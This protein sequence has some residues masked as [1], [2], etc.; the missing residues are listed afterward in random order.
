MLQGNPVPALT[1]AAGRPA[2]ALGV[3]AR[4][5]L[6]TLAAVL[7]VLAFAG[8][9]LWRFAE[10]Q[11]GIV[12]RSLVARA[13]GLAR[14]VDSEFE[15]LSSTL[16]AIAGTTAFQAGNLDAVREHML[17]VGRDIGSQVTLRDAGGNLLLHTAIPRGHE[18]G[19]SPPRPGWL[20]L[21]AAGGSGLVVTDLFTGFSNGAQIY[22]VLLPVTDGA[23]RRLLIGATFRADLLMERLRL[24]LPDPGWR[25]LVVDRSHRI[26]AGTTVSEAAL[27]TDAGP[28]FREGASTVWRGQR[29]D[30]V[31]I[32]F[33]HARTAVGWDVGASLAA[34]QV[35]APVRRAVW[36]LVAVGALLLACAVLLALIAARRIARAMGELAE[37]ATVL[38]QGRPVPP[39][40]TSLREA[41]M[42]GAAL[43]RAANTIAARDGALREREAQLARTQRLARVGGFE[44]AVEHRPDGGVRFTNFRSPEYLAV[45]GLP[46]EAA[47]E[48]HE[49]WV[50]RIHPEDRARVTEDFMAAVW[51]GGPDYLSEYR[52]ATPEGETRWISALA[53]VQRDALGR[54]LRFRGVHVDL[55]ALRRAEARLAENRAALAAAEERL[56]LAVEAGG[57]V[58]FDVEVAS[59]RGVFSPGHFALLGQ[60][61]PADGCGDLAS[62][63]AAIHP[64]DRA[65]ARAAWKRML[66]GGGAVTVEHRVLVPAGERW[67]SAT[68]RLL[69]GN[70]LGASPGTSPN[71]QLPGGVRC[72]GVYAD[73]TGRRTAQAVLEERV[74]EAVAAAEAAQA[75]LAHAHKMEA[76]GQL[77]GGVAHDFNNLL[78]VVASGAALLG[79]REAVR[80]DPGARRLLEGMAGAAERGAALT[81]RML[82][83]ARRQELRMGAV[84]TAAL[85]LALRDIL[86]RSIGPAT[87]LEIELPDD[88]WWVLADPNQLELAILN[89]CVN[90]RDAMAPERCPG[91][92]VRVTARNAPAGPRGGL[93]GAGDTPPGGDCLVILV[94][95]DGAGMDAET[96]ARATEPF[97]TTKGVG[98]GTGL[99]L[100]MVHGLCA[101]SG[102]AL[103]LV[104]A[105]GQGTTAEIWLPRAEP[106]SEA[107]PAPVALLPALPAARRLSVLLVDDDPL[108]LA[109]NAAL[110]ADLG[111][112]ARE[113][114]SAAAA[115]EALAAGPLP[116]LVITDHAMPGMTGAELAARLA[117]LHPGLPVILATGYADL[118]AGEA[119]E[120]PR[121][122][123]PFGR[124]ALAAALAAA[125]DEAKAAA[126]AGRRTG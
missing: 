77:T 85:I 57:L 119:P 33:T 106:G 39:I 72:V 4:L 64:E 125:T 122:D 44:V 60:P 19:Q 52:V 26:V 30:G 99:G 15:S 84:D 109:S 93:A 16:R 81:R 34:E 88:L 123:K 9:V 63:E 41:N 7:P 56:R 110:L 20:E 37:A 45:H 21:V 70:S 96:L 112:T 89:L 1:K 105:P 51:G 13:E 55:S 80:A 100:S 32:V 107:A 46:P 111:H 104:S 78:Q 42:V 40:Q 6:L 3:R 59:G 25:V 118:T 29:A 27:G 86:A 36:A 98:R 10:A 90:A 47:D 8:L 67:I 65:G 92:C 102:G 14:V 121:L 126:G 79:K 48:P 76:L 11:R 69:A 61:A 35:D 50:E 116:D 53:E 28:R 66:V 38:G 74:R 108:V 62:W 103:R 22:G 91:G 17:A 114:E 49:A 87:P 101:Q 5:L 120:V 73:I 94:S 68:G 23:G 31:P 24:S 58:A 2:R 75:Q 82:A 95:D 43:S 83:F 97:F 54:A 113:V 18:E 115:L 12:E 117:A 71:P 124:D